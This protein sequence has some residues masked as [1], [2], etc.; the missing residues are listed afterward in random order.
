ME[1][2]TLSPDLVLTFPIFCCCSVFQLCPT[3]CDAMDCSTLGF[4]VL[5]YIP[6]F[7]QT[8]IHWVNDAIDQSRPLSPPSPPDTSIFPSIRIFSND[9]ALC[10]R[11]PKFWSF[12][13]SP[14]NEYSGLISF[15][16]DWFD[17]PAVQGTLRSLLQ[18][19]SSK[20]S[21]LQQPAFLLCSSHIP[22]WPL[23]KPQLWLYRPL[24]AE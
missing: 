4:H 11:W 20:A 8:H 23:E 24:L 1:P 7:A 13:I 9:L 15:R 21:I 16:I 5:H 14:S 10:I 3:L 2:L 17:L 22:T 12:S 6:E 19:H 18:H